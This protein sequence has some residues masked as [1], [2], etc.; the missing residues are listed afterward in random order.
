MKKMR[1]V[2]IFDLPANVFAE[3]GVNTTLVIAY[4]P[5]EKE[6]KKVNQDGYKIFFKDIQRVG[7]EIR[8]SKRVK[9]FLKQYKINYETFD[10]EINNEGE[11]IVDEEFTSTVTQ[12]REWCKGQEKTLQELFIKEK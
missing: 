3:T 8:T 11:A 10:V 9:I 4:K 5:T 6:L 1:V 2:A 7:Y 12:F